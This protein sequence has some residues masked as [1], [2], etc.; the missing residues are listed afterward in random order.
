[1]TIQGRT[2]GA[3]QLAPGY[4]K[5]LPL[6]NYAP[7]MNDAEF[8]AIRA[9]I[10]GNTL[11]DS[12]RCYSLWKLVEQA[13]Q[14]EGDLLEVGV[15]RG[16]TGALIA[17]QASR[18]RSDSRRSAE[19]IFDPSQASRC[20]FLADTFNGVAK[21]GPRDSYYRGG[22]HANTSLKVVES[23][24]GSLGIGNAILLEGVF[25]EDTGDLIDDH[26]FCFCH[27]DVDVY[28][29]A[30]D[31]FEWVWPRLTVGGIVVYDD[32]G[33]YGCEGVTAHVNEIFPDAQ[34]TVIHN[35]NGQAIVVKTA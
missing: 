9:A 23:L 1:M 35:L 14:H 6:A 3:V 27:I 15:W 22:E 19:D 32:Y 7:W 24:L 20:V 8:A 29:S 2:S 17:H 33:F 25:P 4:Q 21:A 30:R 18:A 31:V 13:V 11:V 28:Q 34:R 16:G 10:E 5:V 12:Y 26:R